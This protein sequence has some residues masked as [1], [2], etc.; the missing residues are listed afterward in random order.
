MQ[1]Q[2]IS[3][4]RAQRVDEKNEFICLVIF[5]SRVMVI[6]MSEMVYFLYFQLITAKNCTSLGKIFKCI[7]KVL[8]SSFRKQYGLLGSELPLVRCQHLKYRIS[9]FFRWLIIFF[10]F[11]GIS[12]HNISRTVQT[13]LTIPFSSRTE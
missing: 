4:D 7:W 5:T 11:F 6:K 9:V 12:I 8:L 3:T 10:F 2:D 13:L 1:R